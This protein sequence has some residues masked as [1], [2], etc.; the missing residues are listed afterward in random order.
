MKKQKLKKKKFRT[1]KRKE[2]I[3]LYIYKVVVQNLA[4]NI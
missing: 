2:I 4:Q 1:D 3:D